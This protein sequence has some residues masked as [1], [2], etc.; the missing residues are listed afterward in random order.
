ME[1]LERDAFLALLDEY[2]RDAASGDSRVVLLAG[3]AGVGKTALVEALQHRRPDDRWLWGTCDGSFTPQPLAPLL[4]IADQLGG[5]LAVACRSSE[6]RSTVFRLLRDELTASD[7]LTVLVFEDMHWAD[8][9]S[10][11]LLQFLSRRVRDCRVLIIATYRDDALV[12]DH[13]LRTILGQVGAHRWARRISVPPLTPEA[14]NLLA[15][16]SGVDAKHVYELTGG[17]PFFVREALASSGEQL[18]T[19]VHD[20]VQARICRISPQ[21]RDVVD[22]VAVL[23]SAATT[24]DVHRLTAASSEVLDECLASAALVVTGGTLGFR[25]EL[26]RAAIESSLPA[27]RRRAMNAA[28][29]EILDER[30]DVGAA[31]LAHH[32][33]LAEDGAAVQVHAPRAG[34]EAA[35]LGSHREAAAQFERALRWADATSPDL[36]CEWRERLA[37]EYGLLDQWERSAELRERVTADWRMAGNRRRESAALRKLAHAQWR[38]CDGEAHRRLADEAVAVLGDEAPCPEL[39]WALGTQA[40]V[41]M[42]VDQD[43]SARLARQA[44]EIAHAFGDT[45]LLAEALNTEACARW[46]Q[47]QDASQLLRRSLDIALAGGHETQTGRAYSNLHAHLC[48]R[49]RHAEADLVYEQGLSYWEVDTSTYEACLKGGQVRA[50]DR[51]GEWDE[52]LAL[53][54]GL[55]TRARNDLSPVNRLNPLQGVGRILARCGDPEGADMLD[56]AL[57]LARSLDSADWLT[58]ALIGSAECAWLLGD[59]ASARAMVLEALPLMVGIDPEFAGELACWAPR[60]GVDVPEGSRRTGT[61]GPAPPGQHRVSAARL[62]EL[63]LHYDAALTLLDSSDAD[64]MRE[65]VRRL[66]ALGAT[67]VSARARSLMRQRGVTAIPRGSRASTKDDPLGLTSR[68]REVLTLVTDGASN[69]EIAAQLVIS[70]KTVDHHVSSI[71]AKLGVTSR[72]EAAQAAL[73]SS[74]T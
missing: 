11:D 21:A 40:S 63:D 18:L 73:S 4:D 55:V 60:V 33:E 14:V 13:P 51:R 48:S 42:D 43:E 64:D 74:A 2:A 3:E 59:D 46:N 6:P 44:A 26:A 36:V 9:A 35:H 16:E 8:E 1:L 41:L 38:L 54:R 19:S 34:E 15:Q 70:V 39:G 31:R 68:E 57:L 61:L 7:H 29:L 25:H 12:R 30:G 24:D 23:G 49:Y 50:L 27:H 67:A 53:G 22:W 10:L 5:T 17:N 58:D 71:L 66:D 52:A 72:G 28:V 56:E 65:S 69:A 62:Q 20:A 32:A 45:A 37:D 47:G